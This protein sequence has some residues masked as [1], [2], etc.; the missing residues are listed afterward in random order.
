M[1]TG[2][3]YRG[4]T[5]F[6]PVYTGDSIG[7]GHHHHHRHR[8]RHHRQPR[9]FSARILSALPRGTT[10]VERQQTCPQKCKYRS[11]NQPD[12]SHS[13][14]CSSFTG[15]YTEAVRH[16]G[17]YMLL[18]RG[19]LFAQ[20]CVHSVCEHTR[21]YVYLDVTYRAQVCPVDT[22]SHR[23]RRVSLLVSRIRKCDRRAF[24]SRPTAP[25]FNS[26]NLRPFRG[27]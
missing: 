1:C 6:R 24:L 4:E 8:H 16:G 2:L 26:N 13:L 22:G 10:G 9:V 7:R 18:D 12:W 3:C 23:P 5:T 14:E 19:P 20:I 11:A 21:P 27:P 15:A 17:R 25:K